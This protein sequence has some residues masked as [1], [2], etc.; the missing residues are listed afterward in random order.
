MSRKT[1]NLTKVFMTERIG[2]S[3]SDFHFKLKFM[4]QTPGGKELD[5]IVE[6]PAWGVEY[7]SQKL[8]EVQKEH[9][10]LLHNSRRAL[11]TGSIL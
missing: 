9:E 6:F 8:H 10:R 4:G 3:Y 5:V 2:P 11:E 1:V 7:L